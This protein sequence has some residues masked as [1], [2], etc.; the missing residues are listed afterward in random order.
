MELFPILFSSFFR[1][2]LTR[3]CRMCGLNLKTEFALMNHILA[4]HLERSCGM[5]NFK[6][7]ASGGGGAG[8]S[9]EK[10]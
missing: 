6:T 5:C 1:P 2:S 4:E 9:G 3:L 7:A 8:S 10:V